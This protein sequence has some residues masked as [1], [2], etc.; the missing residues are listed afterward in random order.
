MKN[1]KDFK[2]DY[3]VRPFSRYLILGQIISSDHVMIVHS[4]TIYASD[5]IF[6]TKSFLHHPYPHD[7]SLN[8]NG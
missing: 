7:V 5:L 3:F 4:M 8:L 1:S 6:T 2:H